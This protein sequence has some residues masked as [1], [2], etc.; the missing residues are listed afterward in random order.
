MKRLLALPLFL[1]TIAA[2]TPAPKVEVATGDWNDLPA[3]QSRGYDHLH[4]NVMLRIWELA[5]SRTCR[6]SGYSM[7]KLDFR[8]SFATQFNPNGSIARLIIPQLNCPEAEGIVAGALLEMIQAG[9]YRRH[10]T[11][12]DGWYQG[13]LSFGYDGGLG[14]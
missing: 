10:G 2:T 11:S 13:S 4:S 14:T 3:L 12:P 8:M 1:A 6:I 9:D 7:G 5:Q